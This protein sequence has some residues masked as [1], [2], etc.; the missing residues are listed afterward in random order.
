MVLKPYFFTGKLKAAAE[1]HMKKNL[2][3]INKSLPCFLW[4]P[5]WEVLGPP[6]RPW[7]LMEGHA[8][9]SLKVYPRKEFQGA[10]GNAKR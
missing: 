2:L 9:I 5:S 3:L 4:P 8:S 6:R 7:S 1:N 10:Q